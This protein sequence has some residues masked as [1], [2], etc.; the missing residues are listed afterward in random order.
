M[1]LNQIFGSFADIR[2]RACAWVPRNYRVL[3]IRRLMNLPL[4]MQRPDGQ[5]TSRCAKIQD[6]PCHSAC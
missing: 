5:A 1:T 2:Y 6:A 3:T 4:M